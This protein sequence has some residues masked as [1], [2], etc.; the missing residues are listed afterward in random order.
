MS[1]ARR[2]SG[3]V[4]DGGVLVVSGLTGTWLAGLVTNPDLASLLVVSAPIVGSWIAKAARDY[5]GQ[6]IGQKVFGKGGS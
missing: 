6:T 4:E 2:P 3:Y 1:E 5:L